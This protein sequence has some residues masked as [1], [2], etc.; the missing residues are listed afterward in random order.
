MKSTWTLGAAALI[1]AARIPYQGAPSPAG[2]MR[3]SLV[4]MAQGAFRPLWRHILWVEVSDALASRQYLDALSAL[5][6]LEAADGS[7]WKAAAFRA[8]IVAYDI[9]SRETSA[10]AKAAR[11]A[12][13]LRVLERAALR[14]AAPELCLTAGV[15]LM[16]PWVLDPAVATRLEK[17]WKATPIDTAARWLDEGLRRAPGSGEMRIGAVEAWRLRGIEIMSRDGERRLASRAFKKSADSSQAMAPS[18]AKALAE[19]WGALD[20]ALDAG[21]RTELS[22]AGGALAR[23]IDDVD[24]SG[25]YRQVEI[26]L[27]QAAL[28]GFLG[29]AEAR[30]GAND[31][32]GSL[33]VLQVALSIPAQP[34]AGIDQPKAVVDRVVL[35][36]EKV[37]SADQTTSAEVDALLERIRRPPR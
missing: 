20:R 36:L 14:S 35:L 32:A 19:A 29:A 30:F 11:V 18:L 34:S 8:H 1:I 5:R 21:T 6:Q 28:P 3:G 24:A 10:A 15:M 16:E 27:F 26:H 2:D 7:D 23:V 17:T 4:T 22:Q 31:I 25:G 33:S 9:G 37:R 12:E 13:A